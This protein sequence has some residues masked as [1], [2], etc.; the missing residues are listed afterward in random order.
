MQ[1]PESIDLKVVPPGPVASGEA[2]AGWNVAR[3]GSLGS[4]NIGFSE[5]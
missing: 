4:V 3:A 2:A 1:R 5:H